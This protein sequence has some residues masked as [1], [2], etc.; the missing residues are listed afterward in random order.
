M[1][2]FDI[3]TDT[4]HRY[5]LIFHHNRVASIGFDQIHWGIDTYTG[6]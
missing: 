3:D 2:G 5:F 6:N 4:G 1:D